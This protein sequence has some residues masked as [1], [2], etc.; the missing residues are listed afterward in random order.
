MTD[1]EKTHEQKI[2]LANRLKK[3]FRHLWKYAKRVQTTA[4]RVYHRDIPEIPLEID[5][6]DGHLHIAEYQRPHDRAPEEHD[7]WLQEM[8]DT[9]A[10][11]LTVPPERVF[12]KQ[13]ERQRGKSQYEPVARQN[14]TITVEEQGLLFRVNLSDYLDTGLFLDHRMLRM[15][16][17]KRC[18]NKR[19]LNLFAYTG[20]FTAYAIA[21]GARST[22]TVD[23]SRTYLDWAKDNLRLNGLFTA[24]HEF[25]RGDVIQEIG[26]LRNEGRRFDLIILDPPSF[27]NSKNMDVTLDIQRDHV[28]LIMDCLSLL[29][30]GG[31]LVF[32]TNKRR[33]QFKR[34]ELQDRGV[35]ISSLTK[36]TMPEDFLGTNIHHVWSLKGDAGRLSGRPGH[37][38]KPDPDQETRRKR[39]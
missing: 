3:R 30:P 20:S 24:G 13:R 9:A 5:W 11:T 25:R 27:S 32:S 12:F 22:V 38:H 17:A 37:R 2:F 39:K 31:E 14:Y 7:E 28:P 19:V 35:E 18:T 16:V 8:V 26:H 36:L 23:L 29:D 10:R 33:F 1:H 6:Y 15:H 34:Q 21:G 4:F